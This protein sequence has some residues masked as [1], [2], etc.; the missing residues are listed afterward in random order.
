MSGENLEP[1]GWDYHRGSLPH[2]LI[3]GFVDLRSDFRASEIS[4]N[5]QQQGEK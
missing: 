2:V 3:K 5:M 4:K 1:A